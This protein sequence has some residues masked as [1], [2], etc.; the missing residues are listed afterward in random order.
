MAATNFE[1]VVPYQMPT[2]LTLAGGIYRGSGVPDATNVAPKGSLYINYD[3]AA[4]A[5]RLYIATDSAGTWAA[6]TAA[7]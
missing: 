2:T 4:A 6:Y 5:T 1:L 3:A 7:A